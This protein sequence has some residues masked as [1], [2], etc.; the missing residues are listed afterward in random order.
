[1]CVQNWLK[2][3]I[4]NLEFYIEEF[5]VMKKLSE[6]CLRESSEMPCV[7]EISVDLIANVRIYCI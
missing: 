7:G 2:S 4:E 5:I 6:I 1:M 3:V